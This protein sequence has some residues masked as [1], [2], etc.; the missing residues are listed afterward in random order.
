MWHVGGAEIYLLNFGEETG[1][2]E[3]FWGLRHRR[4]DNINMDL[5]EIGCVLIAFICFHIR[6][7][8]GLL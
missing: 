1:R 7:R 5:T 4:E 2:K 6:T 8:D 3:A